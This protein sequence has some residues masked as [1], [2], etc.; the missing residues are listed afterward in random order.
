MSMTSQ[1]R[2]TNGLGSVFGYFDYNGRDEEIDKEKRCQTK[3]EVSVF[4]AVMREGFGESRGRGQGRARGGKWNQRVCDFCLL[5][6]L[7]GM[8]SL[9]MGTSCEAKRAPESWV[10]RNP[11]N[12]T[13]RN[14]KRRETQT[15]LRVYMGFGVLN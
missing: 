5:C 2:S 9:E 3:K 1:G 4:V 13:N 7:L 11:I 15:N 10:E 8:G 12:I 6:L 14:D